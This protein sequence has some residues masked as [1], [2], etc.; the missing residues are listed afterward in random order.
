MAERTSYAPGTPSFVDVTVPDTSKAAAFYGRLFGWN[1]DMSDDPEAGGFGMFMLRGKSVGGLSPLP[2]PQ[3][4]PHWKVYV[5]VED[6]DKTSELVPSNGGTVMVPPMDVMDAG[7]MA[8]YQDCCGSMVAAWHPN[9]T[10]GV[11]LV[12]EP[13]SFTWNELAT[14]DMAKSRA[15]YTSVFGWD[16]DEENSDDGTIFAVN[17]NIICGA[18]TAGEGEFPAWS[19]WFAVE[20]CDAATALATEAGGTVLMPPNDMDFGRGAVVADDQGAVFGLGAVNEDQIP[21]T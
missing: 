12:N 9:Q 5:T 18:H 8:I 19:I 7:R 15:F 13:G 4:P 14:A 10:A 6:V 20:D 17:G 1:A 11:E 3:V 16:I 2:D 21:Q